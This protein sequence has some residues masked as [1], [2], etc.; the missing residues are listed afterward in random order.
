M[1]RFEEEEVL[2]FPFFYFEVSKVVSYQANKSENYD[3]IQM[4]YEIEESTEENLQS[5]N[6]NTNQEEAVAAEKW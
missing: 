6:P 1:S 3:I 2:I 5:S 4:P